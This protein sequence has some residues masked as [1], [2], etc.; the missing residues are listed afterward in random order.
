MSFSLKIGNTPLVNQVQ[1]IIGN[2]NFFYQLKN[3]NINIPS[4]TTYSITWNDLEPSDYSV[5]STGV[6]TKA[7][8]N[9]WKILQPGY[10]NIDSEVL[11]T[12]IATDRDRIVV[13]LSFLINGVKVPFG[14]SFIDSTFQNIAASSIFPTFITNSTSNSLFTKSTIRTSIDDEITLYL[15]NISNVNISINAISIRFNRIA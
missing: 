6:I 9:S 14:T 15:E 4:S 1:E 8:N 13:K 5:N 3:T 2:Q 10:Y 11:F 7:S 12:A